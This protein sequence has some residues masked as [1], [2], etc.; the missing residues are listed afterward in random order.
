MEA[1]GAAGWGQMELNL[2]VCLPHQYDEGEALLKETSG[3]S[4]SLMLLSIPI[5]CQY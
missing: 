4:F 2:G 3:P 5:P 1:V